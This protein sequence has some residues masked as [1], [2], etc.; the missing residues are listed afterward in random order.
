MS[1]QKVKTREEKKER[2]QNIRLGLATTATTPNN[3]TTSASSM[4]AN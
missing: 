1:K 4:P 3:N 2:M